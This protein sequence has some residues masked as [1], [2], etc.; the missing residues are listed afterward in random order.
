ML[1]GADIVIPTSA[2]QL[3]RGGYRLALRFL[4]SSCPPCRLAGC[5]ENIS[6]ERKYTFRS[7][8]FRR[9]TRLARGERYSRFASPLRCRVTNVTRS[10]LQRGDH[11][12]NCAR[13]LRTGHSV[14]F[15]GSAYSRTRRFF[16]RQTDRR[17]VSN[18]TSPDDNCEQ[19]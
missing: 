14:L 16:D 8:G 3:S 11:R 12:A 5:I 13:L 1:L 6:S 4:D 2:R 18:P 10:S 9:D 7:A 15:S 17:G 19:V